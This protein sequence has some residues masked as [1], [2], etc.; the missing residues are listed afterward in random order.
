M[1]PSEEAAQPA[2]ELWEQ[3]RPIA[4]YPVEPPVALQAACEWS[5]E[6][7]LFL[8]FAG[9]R[10]VVAANVRCAWDGGGVELLPHEFTFHLPEPALSLLV[11]EADGGREGPLLVA[12]CA[13]QLLLIEPGANGA[14]STLRTIALDAPT[15]APAEADDDDDD[16]G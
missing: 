10:E 11:T 3:L 16:D 12:L 7:A 2:A 14:G 4:S 8:G 6:R 9:R 13:S 15:A 5:A 1:E